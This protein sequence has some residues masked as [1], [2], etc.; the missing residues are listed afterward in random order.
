MEVSFKPWAASGIQNNS[1]L[2]TNESTFLSFS[3]FKDRYKIKPPFLSFLG[4]ISAIKLL[5]NK[6]KQERPTEDSHYDNFRLKLIQASKSTRIVYRKLV[7][8]RRKKPQR[9][10]MKWSMDCM[11]EQN[12]PVDWVAIYKNRQSR[13]AC[14]YCLKCF[15]Y[16]LKDAKCWSVVNPL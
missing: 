16:M 13:T 6:T 5:W 2:M 15:S 14:G 4:V 11:F 12:E 1:D 3:D 9:S 8:K 7:D 10:Q